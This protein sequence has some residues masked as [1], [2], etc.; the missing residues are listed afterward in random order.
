MSAGSGHIDAIENH[1]VAVGEARDRA[2]RRTVGPINRVSFVAEQRRHR[3]STWQLSA[4]CTLA[5]L[6]TGLPLSLVMTPVVFAVALLVL[7]VT[8]PF[9]PNAAAAWDAYGLVF[10][11]LFDVAD[12]LDR[13]PL[14]ALLP[15]LALLAA[16][17]VTPGVVTMATLYWWLG[18]VFARA[19][20]GA[21]LLGLGAR[22]PNAQDLEERQLVNVVEEMAIAAGLQPPRV[23]LLDVTVANAAAVGSAPE[24]AVV[25]I[26]R[27][28]LDELDR[29]DTQGVLGHLIGSIGN[30]DLGIALTIVRT[31]QTFGLAS[32]LLGVPFSSQARGTVRELAGFALG[33]S[34]ADRNSRADLLLTMLSR[35]LNEVSFDDVDR[36][37]G[38]DE[39]RAK[40]V[41]SWPLKIRVYA[42]FPLWFATNMAKVAMMLLSSFLAEPVIAL[43]WRTRRYLADATAVQLTRDPNGLA[44]ALTILQRWGG[45]IPGG[46]WAAHLFIV[47]GQVASGRA[48]LLRTRLEAA[49]S[50]ASWAERARIAREAAE[51]EPDADEGSGSMVGS[52][53]S[54]VNYHPPLA[55]RLARLEAL[56][57]TLPTAPGSAPGTGR[58]PA[59]RGAM[60]L[61]MVIVVPLLALCVVLG[62]VA[63][64]LMMM[65]LALAIFV[66]MGLLYV[67]YSLL[68]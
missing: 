32:T 40:G 64:G 3:R 13:D 28:L 37:L 62:L 35:D 50:R 9:T 58:S 57:A 5:V 49:G 60:A 45:I 53:T 12:R 2:W 67:I 7:V 15:K 54:V 22:E 47:G 36:V 20:T 4:I 56:G 25:V 59:Q 26:S 30:G 41:W 63:L 23:M 33:R 18:R 55:K 46:K 43:L 14:A 11:L 10:T 31:F 17:M 29:D 61:L 65:L 8:R 19:G 52:H 27:R 6:I 24:D 39:Q 34:G 21:L 68:R 38:S 44:S 1:V 66:C 16:V 48:D 42:L 51:S